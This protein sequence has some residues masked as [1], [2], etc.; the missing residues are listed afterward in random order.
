MD[1][2]AAKRWFHEAW[3]RSHADPDSLRP[4]LGGTRPATVA[5]GSRER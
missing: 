3:S 2:D 4:E 1:T 5:E